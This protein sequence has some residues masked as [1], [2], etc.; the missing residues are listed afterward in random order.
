MDQPTQVLPEPVRQVVAAFEAGMRINEEKGIAKEAEGD[1]STYLNEYGS[2]L[3]TGSRKRPLEE[4]E[5]GLEA[6]P[7]PKKQF[8][9]EQETNDTVEEASGEWPQEVK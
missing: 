6:S 2:N 7:T 5:G 3:A 4:L 9:E 1:M 8:V